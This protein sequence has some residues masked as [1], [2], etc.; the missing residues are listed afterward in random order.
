MSIRSALSPIGR[1]VYA[2]GFDPLRALS[3]IRYTP[4]YIRDLFAY[5]SHKEYGPKFRLRLSVLYPILADYNDASGTASGHY[6][7][8]DLLVAR[9]VFAAKPAKHIDI[10]SRVDGFIAHLLCFREVNYVDIRPLK[11]AVP[12]LHFICSDATNLSEFADNSVES[13]SSLH[14]AEHF[15]L[16]RYGDPVDPQA[17]FRFMQSL[18]RVLA[19]DGRLYFAV[20]VG[21]ERVEFNAHRVFSPSTVLE[22]FADV[23]LLSF[24][25]VKDDGKLYAN[26]APH[27]GEDCRYGCGIFEFTKTATV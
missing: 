17:C 10:G 18:A 26:V 9:K 3:A 8:Q 14:A 13:I 25:L 24:S 4:R 5:R 23:K 1:V 16:G 2:F 15:G 11:S 6:F 20:P 7:H 21:R 12:G 19:L 22:S 27:E